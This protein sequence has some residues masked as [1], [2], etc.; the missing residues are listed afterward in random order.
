MSYSA[1][2]VILMKRGFHLEIEGKKLI[3]KLANS[4][5]DRR[6]TTHI[7]SEQEKLIGTVSFEEIQS[8]L[9]TKSLIDISNNG[10]A[11]AVS[12][13]LGFK[14]GKVVYIYTHNSSDC[15]KLSSLFQD[16]KDL[17]QI[18]GSPFSS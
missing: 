6:Y 11:A 1:I 17:I 5:N 9:E 4:M 3:R 2:A 8:M 16:P 7:L 13:L 12:K 18:E 14:S 15:I 10:H